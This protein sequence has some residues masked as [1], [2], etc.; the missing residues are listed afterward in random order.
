MMLSPQQRGVDRFTHETRN[1]SDPLAHGLESHR[2]R[3]S[4]TSRRMNRYLGEYETSTSRVLSAWNDRV[5]TSIDGGQKGKA[6]MPRTK[7]AN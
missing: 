4:Y 1:R 2:V 3:S 7:V 6:S 5:I